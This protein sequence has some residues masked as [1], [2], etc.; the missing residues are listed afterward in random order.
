M[1]LA[2]LR[3]ALT[4]AMGG[5]TITTSTDATW[6]NDRINNGYDRLATF[7]GEVKDPAAPRRQFRVLRFFE[8][9]DVTERSLSTSLTSNFVTPSIAS[10]RKVHSVQDIY[11]KTNKRILSR[12]PMNKARRWNPDE[13]GK[14]REWA[15]AGE[16]GAIGYYIRPRPQVS[17]DDITVREI[18]YLRPAL[19]SADTD[20]PV[21]PRDWHI[22]ILYA[23]AEEAGMLLEQDKMVEKFGAKFIQYIAERRSPA[24]E[25][26]MSGGLR[27]NTVGVTQ[28]GGGRVRSR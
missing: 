23:A 21:I 9:I 18:T 5:V 15:P 7:Q 19:L 25:A 4:Q 11:D 14:P 20:E 22:A 2:E 27:W 8:L 16:S 12:K 3:T 1:T 13:D 17:G 6:K 26:G 24:E 10:T 28:A